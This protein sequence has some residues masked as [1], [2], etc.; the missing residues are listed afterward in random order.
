MNKIGF[1][2]A[3]LDETNDLRKELK[4]LKEEKVG[5]CLVYTIKNNNTSS[6][7]IYS[8]VGKANAAHATSILINK[9]NIEYDSTPVGLTLDKSEKLYTLKYVFTLLW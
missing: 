6:Y 5:G 9:Y 8:G 7:L 4:V 2:V 3:L 1:V